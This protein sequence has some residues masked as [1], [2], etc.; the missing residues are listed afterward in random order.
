MNIDILNAYCGRELV[1]RP[2][3]A[4]GRLNIHQAIPPALGCRL[5]R[6]GFKVCYV[7]CLN[8]DSWDLFPGSVSSA[9][10]HGAGAV[11]SAPVGAFQTFDLRAS[12]ITRRI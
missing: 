12:E 1:S 6:R 4:Q 10:R 8:R 3:L 11:L 7:E 5:L 9:T 2:R